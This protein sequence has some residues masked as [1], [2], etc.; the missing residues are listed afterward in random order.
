LPAPTAH[1]AALAIAERVLTRACPRPYNAKGFSPI[2][3]A[4]CYLLVNRKKGQRWMSHMPTN[5]V[6]ADSPVLAERGRLAIVRHDVAALVSAIIHPL[7]FPLL[8]LIVIS[9]AFTHGNLPRTLLYAIVAVGLTALPVAA[10][11][12]IQV[13]RGAWSDL[14]VSKR[15]QRYTL[16]PL[17]LACLGILLYVFYRLHAPRQNVVAVVSLAAAN[18]AN[19]IINL[20]WKISAHATTAA[21]CAALLWQLTPAWGPPAVA[22]AALVGWS[23]VELKRHT[24]GQV[25][26]GWGVGLTSAILAVRVGL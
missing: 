12:W 26:A 8:T 1:A 14:D 25:L 22:G 2:I 15:T 23:R 9:L 11:V 19:G 17:T 24:T 16:Y 21:M 13:K 4:H 6:H 3:I 10:V 5:E 20:F 18:V 7:L